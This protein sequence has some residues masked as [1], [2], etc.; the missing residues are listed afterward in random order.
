MCARYRPERALTDV[1][2]VSEQRARSSAQESET[3]RARDIR[4][5]FYLDLIDNKRPRQ[6][7]C[8]RVFG[9]KVTLLA[10]GLHDVRGNR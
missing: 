3:M 6:Y 4:A 1:Y 10:S 9:G 2:L 5:T 7:V 8:A